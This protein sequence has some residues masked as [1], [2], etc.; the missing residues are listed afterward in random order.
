M[1]WNL[2]VLSLSIPVTFTNWDNNTYVAE[3]QQRKETIYAK[4][5]QITRD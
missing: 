2:Q 3:I 1:L 5:A 4:Q